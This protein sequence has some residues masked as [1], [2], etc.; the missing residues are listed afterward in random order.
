MTRQALIAVLAMSGFAVAAIAATPE[1]ELASARPVILAVNAD[2]VPAMKAHDARRVAA[3]YA[4][5]AVFVVPDGQVLRGRAAIETATEARFKPGR[6]VVSGGLQQDGLTFG[7]AGLIYEWGHGGLTVR[8]ADGQTHSTS[9]PYLTV[10]KRDAA[11]QWRI[12]RNLA[13]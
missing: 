4:D 9:G 10:W 11:G 5:D 3:P 1:A 12:V 8:D 13:F 2:W 7:G 6:E